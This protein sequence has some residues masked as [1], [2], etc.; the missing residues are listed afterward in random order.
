MLAV[1][2]ANHGRNSESLAARTQVH[3]NVRSHGQPEGGALSSKAKKIR[4]HLASTSLPIQREFSTMLLLGLALLAVAWSKHCLWASTSTALLGSKVSN[5]PHRGEG[6]DADAG[7]ARGDGR[8]YGLGVGATHT[9]AATTR[10]TE[11]PRGGQ[12]A[13][14]AAVAW[15]EAMLLLLA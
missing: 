5:I 14:E 13:E 3:V 15:L 6:A 11:S 9:A 2:V 12:S 1:A 4:K 10:T 8:F 7:G